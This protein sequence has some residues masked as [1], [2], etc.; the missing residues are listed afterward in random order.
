MMNKIHNLLGYPKINLYLCRKIFGMGKKIY[1]QYTPPPKTA[2]DE[3]PM[4]EKTDIIKSCVRNGIMS[5]QNVRTAYN[6]YVAGRNILEGIPD[7]QAN[8]T[9]FGNF[10]AGGGRKDSGEKVVVHQPYYAYD[11]NGRKIDDTLY[12]NVDVA[13]PEVTVIP[14]SMKS[15]AQR[16]ADERFRQRSNKNYAE[17]QARDYTTRQSIAAQ[18]EWENSPQKRALDLGIAAAQGIGMASDVVSPFF[19]GLPVYS[20]L[21]G[22]Q[23]LDKATSTNN[24]AD[25]AD[26]ALWLSPML[27]VAG[28]KVY[29]VAKPAVQR[30]FAK[31][32]PASEWAR[33]GNIQS[34][35]LNFG[36][37]EDGTFKFTG[38]VEDPVQM[39]LK[40]AQAK[41]YDVSGINIYDLSKDTPE[42]TAFIESIAKQYN[43][44]P[45]QTKSF[46]LS[47][48]ETHGHAAQFAGTRNI[49]HDNA[50]NNMSAR[51]SHEIDHLFHYPEETIP[52]GAYYPRLEKVYGNYFKQHNNTE[53]SARGSQLH[54]YF[55]HIGNE[56]ITEDM[57][58]YARQHYIQDTG[59]DNDMHDFLWAIKD[60]KKVANWLTKYATGIVPFGMLGAS[61]PNSKE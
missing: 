23:A 17:Q 42:N 47:H 1:F 16:N 33:E 58:E 43:L 55:G 44:T 2:W 24:V 8:A 11:R 14:D 37:V 31:G 45:E 15:P 12:Y 46:L 20:G 52:E 27:T 28:K 5:L 41:G 30:A 53:I 61:S 10:L 22:A 3:L 50:D 34:N 25:Y 54:D 51:I 13:L 29:D 18:R 48:L 38:F 19:G 40:R 4:I 21:K 56:P 39:H 57:L 60:N 35:L 26:A 59:L 9:E 36:N 49:I 7:Y 32:T 6:N